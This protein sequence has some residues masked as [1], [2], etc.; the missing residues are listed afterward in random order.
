VIVMAEQITTA[1]IRLDDGADAYV[2]TPAVGQPRVARSS[3]EP[4]CSG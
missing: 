2:A 3:P 1:W 4:R